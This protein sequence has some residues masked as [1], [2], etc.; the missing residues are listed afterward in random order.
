MEPDRNRPSLPD[1]SGN[2]AASASA[3]RTIEVA[4]EFKVAIAAA[5]RNGPCPMSILACTKP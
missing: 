5:E 2:A 3:E 1:V 4:A